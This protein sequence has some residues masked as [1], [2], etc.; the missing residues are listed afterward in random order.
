MKIGDSFVKQRTFTNEEIIAFGE[1]T[2]N[3]GR[4]HTEP[5]ELGRLM[6]QGLL[7]ASLI[8]DVGAELGL[9][10]QAM[11]LNFLRPVYSGDSITCTLRLE[12]VEESNKSFNLLFSCEFLNQNN[13]K[14]LTGEGRGVIFKT[15]E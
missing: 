12:R 7:T 14:V 3:T 15:V 1:L 2:R 13:K 6:V 5:D 9:M 8:T 4:V 11:N 10:G